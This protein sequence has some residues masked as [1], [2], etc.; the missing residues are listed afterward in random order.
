MLFLLHDQAKMFP[1]CIGMNC[2]AI[3]FYLLVCGGGFAATVAVYDVL[4]RCW[5]Y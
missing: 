4:R 5:S 3:P 1:F 2:I